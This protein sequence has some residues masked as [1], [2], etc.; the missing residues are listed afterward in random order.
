MRDT[1]LIH[2]AGVPLPI[3]SLFNNTLRCLDGPGPEWTMRNGRKQTIAPPWVSLEMQALQLLVWETEEKE[4]FAMPA[5]YGEVWVVK[6]MNLEVW[7]NKPIA[8]A[9]LVFTEP[10]ELGQ[11]VSHSWLGIAWGRP[12]MGTAPLWA[13][14]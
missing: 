1:S 12:G 4:F 7:G 10:G 9:D 14:L 2:H 6:R 13:K 3:Y 8:P 5:G 11:A